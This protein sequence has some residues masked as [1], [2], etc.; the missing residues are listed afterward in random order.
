MRRRK[1]K[2][3]ENVAFGN[4]LRHFLTGLHAGRQVTDVRG[5]L[6]ARPLPEARLARLRKV[7]KLGAAAGAGGKSGTSGKEAVEGE[8][9]EEED[10]EDEVRWMK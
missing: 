2:E 3:G 8:D 4:Q 1:E 9:E 5:Y 6:E 10:E 7:F